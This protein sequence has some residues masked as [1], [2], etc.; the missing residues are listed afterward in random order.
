MVGAAGLQA[1]ERVRRAATSEDGVVLSAGDGVL[2]QVAF[3]SGTVW[4]HPEELEKLPEGPAERLAAGELGHLEPYGLRLQSLYLRHAYRYDPLTGLSNDLQLWKLLRSRP[5]LARKP[6]R[7]PGLY[8]IRR[9]LVL[10]SAV[11]WPMSCLTRLA[12]D[13]LRFDQTGSVGLP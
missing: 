6:S 10:I 2:V 4:I 8:C 11:S 9:S 12:S 7:R 1:G 3:P 5:G 13:R